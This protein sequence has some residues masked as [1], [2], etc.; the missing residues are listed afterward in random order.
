MRVPVGLILFA[1][2]GS[3]VQPA[4][5]AGPP[6]VDVF[7][8]VSL[9]FE[10]NLRV[11]AAR[12]DVE[13]AEFQFQRFERNLSQFRPLILE[14]ALDKTAESAVVNGAR[15]SERD[16]EGHV[17]VGMSKEFF[18]GTSL[19]ANT[20]MR[21]TWDADGRNSNPFVRFEVRFPLFSSFTRLERITE[22]SFEESEMLGSWL[23]FIETVGDAIAESQEDYFDLQNLL[24]LRSLVV[25]A[26]ADFAALMEEPGVSGRERDVSLVRDQ[27]QA[28][29]SRLVE[30]DGEIAAAHI[31]LMDRLGLD[32]LPLSSITTMDLYAR[33]FYGAQYLDESPQELTAAAVETD[34]EVLVMETARENAR[35]KRRLAERGE[36]DI[37]GRL[38]GGYDFESRGD[39][40]DKRRGYRAGVAFSVERNDPRLLH[41]SLRRALAEENKYEARIAYRRRQLGNEI[42]RRLGQAASLRSVIREME[43]SRELRRAVFAEK[44]QAYLAG[45]E[46]LDNVIQAR[47]QLFGT[48]RDLLAN[49]SDFFEVVVDLDIATGAYFARLEGILERFEQFGSPDGPPRPPPVARKLAP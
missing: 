49:L 30:Q 14:S 24:A 10:H 27:I 23:D 3:A 4:A 16:D 35:L 40:S 21:Q 9:T 28:Y 8:V 39:D 31:S 42:T 5:A 7:S 44:R 13:A 22:R 45:N 18:D 6:Q 41:L 25:A 36:W 1:A 37:V 11:T 20:G 29:Q 19:E 38:V 48:E 33:D 15:Q 12:F 34:V 43:A 47:G 2:A 46:T 26:Q 32:G 17:S